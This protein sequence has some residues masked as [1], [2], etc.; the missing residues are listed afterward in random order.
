MKWQLFSSLGKEQAQL[1]KD[2]VQ[3]LRCCLYALLL[4]SQNGSLTLFASLPF[5]PPQHILYCSMTVQDPCLGIWPSPPYSCSQIAFTPLLPPFTTSCTAKLRNHTH[6]LYGECSSFCIF[7]SCFLSIL[8]ART[9]FPF[10]KPPTAHSPLLRLPCHLL[11]T[12][13]LIGRMLY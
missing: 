5:S 9:P 13:N 12:T 3:S 8:P 1:D 10:P 4:P 6:T 2:K 7:V 11:R